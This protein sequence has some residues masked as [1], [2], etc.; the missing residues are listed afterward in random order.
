M[1]APLVAIPYTPWPAV[2]TPVMAV[3]ELVLVFV[4]LK[5]PFD[6]EVLQE[7]ASGSATAPAFPA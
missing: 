2:V 3:L 6:A 5:H 7:L 4:I 1:P